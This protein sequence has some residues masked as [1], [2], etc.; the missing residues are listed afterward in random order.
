MLNTG[1]TA[2]GSPPGTYDEDGLDVRVL[3]PV[4]AWRGGRPL[5]VKGARQR[6]LLA[7]LALR[8]GQVVST[9]RLVEELWG[10][11]PPAGAPATLRTY[12]SHLRAALDDGAGDTVLKARKPGYLLH[13]PPDA[14]DAGRFEA[15]VTEGRR[16]IVAGGA[17]TAAGAARLQAA[18]DLWRGPALTGTPIPPS[19]GGRVAFLD[20][21]RIAATEDRI[22]ADLALGRHAVVIGEIESLIAEHPLRERLRELHMLA[23]YRAGRQADALRAYQAARAYLGEELGIEPGPALRELEA[24]ILRHDSSLLVTAPTPPPAAPAP[25]PPPTAATL[26]GRVDELGRLRAAVQSAAAS[27]SGRAVLVM[28]EAGIGKTRLIDTIAEEAADHTTVLRARCDEAAGA[29]AFWP[30]VQ[31]LRQLVAGHEHDASGLEAQLSLLVP[32]LGA[33]VPAPQQPDVDPESARFLLFDAVTTFLARRAADQPHVVL[34]DDVH[35]ADVSSLLLLAFI[36]RRVRDL[37]IALVAT[38]R[39]GEVPADSPLTA[40][41]ALPDVTRI[42]LHGLGKDDVAALLEGA[43]V[44]PGLAGAVWQRTGGNPFFVTELGRMLAQTDDISAVV[45]EGV[46]AVI[47]QRL[48]RLDAADRHVLDTASVIGRDFTLPDV[49]RAAAVDRA[50]VMRAVG[51]AVSLGVV[52]PVLGSVALYRFQ[53]DLL[54]ETVY[55]AIPV[56]ERMALHGRVATAIEEVDRDGARLREIALHLYQSAPVG[57]P[58]KA[59]HYLLRSAALASTALAF[60]DAVLQVERALE[61]LDLAES[62]DD[63]VRTDVLLRLGDARFRAGQSEPARTSFRAAAD[64][65]RR[66]GDGR[67][68]GYAA[69]GYGA[70]GVT[71]G[72]VDGLLCWC[73]EEAIE[74][75]G[76]DA[77]S[78][79]ARLL[80]RLAMELYYSPDLAR[81]AMLAEEAVT[82]ARQTGDRR[83]LGEALA[84]RHFCLRGPDDLEARWAVGAELLALAEGAGDAELTLRA[85]HGRVGDF[86]ELGDI[87]GFETERAAY[88]ELAD[89]LHQARYQGQALAW[90]AL[91]L[92]LEGRYDDLEPVMTQA[93]ELAAAG[94]PDAALQSFGVQLASVRREQARHAEVLDALNDIANRFSGA[95]A[96]RCPQ[97]V[98][99]CEMGRPDDARSIVKVL[100]KG[101]FEDIPRDVN[102]LTTMCL[103]ALV[104]H[105]LDEPTW[106]TRIHELLV[107][108]EDR[109][110]VVGGVSPSACYGSV[111]FYVGLAACTSGDTEKAII[112]FERA[113]AA[114]ESIGAEPWVA[115]VQGAYGAL[116][117]RIGD[118]RGQA[119]FDAAAAT[120]R[121][122]GMAL[123]ERRM[124]SEVFGQ[125]R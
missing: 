28:G 111:A 69:L 105:D 40:M 125:R 39:D 24:A 48:A 53:H 47:G 18:L 119:L 116:L 93:F 26:V 12:V 77:P 13:L 107:G 68:L 122:L 14:V 7:Y 103:L 114:N 44:D 5:T 89:A 70:T 36:A 87:V 4:E 42:A 74:L 112:S 110:V 17:D 72:L 46:R 35:W 90:L 101:D 49:Q 115:H 51:A 71:T 22:E 29:P 10:E 45:P 43:H 81:S 34:I 117:L 83:A 20:E 102:W 41:A 32:S 96:W 64:L 33:A 109:F 79:R 82:L 95:P 50:A 80:A 85:R 106:A 120:A 88:A 97:A 9:E 55:D 118:E 121:R 30:W 15:L 57:D 73:A 38:Y 75:L 98:F 59:V 62:S 61:L 108:F 54:R 86:L 124:A 91:R 8:P 2:Q 25:P 19:L 67:S 123:L 11:H 37:P 52:A 92:L 78:L 84:A 99:A 56:H 66:R 60:E 27:G 3:G 16:L 76:D 113:L 100:A 23:L 21:L 31:V 104:V 63:A 94:N 58:D 65:A 1:A 6:A